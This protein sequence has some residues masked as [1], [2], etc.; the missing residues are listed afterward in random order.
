MGTRH[1][2]THTQTRF[3]LSNATGVL[4]KKHKAGEEK[5]SKK[6]E[7]KERYATAQRKNT[8]LYPNIPPE[9]LSD[10]VHQQNGTA[11]TGEFVHCACCVC[12]TFFSLSLSLSR[13]RSLQQQRKLTTKKPSSTQRFQNKIS[14]CLLCISIPPTSHTHTHT[15]IHTHTLDFLPH[16]LLP[17]PIPSHLEMHTHTEHFS[18]VFPPW[19]FLGAVTS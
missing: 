11:M 16:P 19:F 5:K 9:S 6:E 7:G 13:S 1:T 4:P 3:T 12:N 15:H 18:L 10:P 2:Y 17:R 14:G 8:E